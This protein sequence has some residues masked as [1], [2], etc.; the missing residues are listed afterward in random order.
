VLTLPAPVRQL[1]LRTGA[2]ELVGGDKL[3]PTDASVGTGRKGDKAGQ[4]AV[5]M[6]TDAGRRGTS[7]VAELL[8]IPAKPCPEL[9]RPAHLGS[10]VRLEVAVKFVVDSLGAV[11]RATLQ[12]VKAPGTPAVAPGFVPHI[13]AVGGN[14]RVDRS[15]PEALPKYGAIVADDLLRHVAGLRFRPGT[16][17]GRP[18]RSSVLVACSA[19]RSGH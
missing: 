6:S 1:V 11:D 7:R 18:I 4:H 3:A 17:N 10:E 13:Y 19:D 14:A 5:A 16:H 8:T 9:R 2:I 15:L 12:I